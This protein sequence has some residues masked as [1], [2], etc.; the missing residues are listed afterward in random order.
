MVAISAMVLPGISGSTLL[1]I[2]G[3][4]FPITTA[5][6]EFL[7]M[8]F[9]YFLPLCIFGFGVIAGILLVIKLIKLSLKNFRSQT[10]YCIVG[11]MIGSFYAIIMGPTTLNVPKAPISIDTFSLIFFII[12]GLFIFGLEKLKSIIEKNQK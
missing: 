11:L 7:H 2:F 8:H 6:R 5:I 3:L 4:Y 12:G 9:E 1:L 10:I